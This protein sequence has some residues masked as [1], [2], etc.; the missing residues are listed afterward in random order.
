METSIKEIAAASYECYIRRAFKCGYNQHGAH[1]DYFRILADTSPSYKGKIPQSY[2]KQLERVIDNLI[3]A[4]DRFLN[5]FNLTETEYNQLIDIRGKLYNAN[6]A[7]TI[8]I[9]LKEGV[10]VTKRFK[11]F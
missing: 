4:T 9:I 3:K 8:R 11:E 1:A 6:S 2:D 7:E 5:Q 10:E